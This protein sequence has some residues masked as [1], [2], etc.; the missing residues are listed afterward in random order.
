MQGASFTAA[1]TLAPVLRGISGDA[2][3]TYTATLG[4]SFTIVQ[5]D[6]GVS[7]GFAAVTQQ[8]ERPVADTV[9]AADVVVSAGVRHRG[10]VARV[11]EGRRCRSWA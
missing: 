11:D 6:G 3:N 4:Q 7:G 9:H 2:T 5:A 10:A 8:I 1:G